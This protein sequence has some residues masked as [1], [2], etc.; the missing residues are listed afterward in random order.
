METKLRISA[1][2]LASVLVLLS[3]FLLLQ[4]PNSLLSD[5]KEQKNPLSYVAESFDEW[6]RSVIPSIKDGRSSGADVAEITGGKPVAPNLATCHEYLTVDGRHVMCCPPKGE[7]EETAIDF[8]FPDPSSPKRIRRPAHLLDRAYIAKYHKAV[9]LMKQLNYSDPRSFTRQANIHCI[10]CTGAHDQVNSS[11][12]FNIHKS[13]FFFPWHRFLIYFHERILGELIGDDTFA[14][15]YWNWDSPIGMQIPSFYMS[16]SFVDKDRDRAHF[17]PQIADLNYN[18]VESG[19]SPDQQIATNLAFMYHQM[20]SGAKKVELFMG[21]RR[22]AGEEGDCTAP[23]TIE[24]APHNTV[25][26]WVGS[27]L[28]PER[29]NMGSFYSAARD[30]IFYAHHANIDRLWIIWRRL[31]GNVPEIVDPAWLDSHFYF[32][33]ENARLIRVKLSDCLELEKLGYAYEETDLPWLNA[34]PKPS[35]PPRIA[36]HI[37]KEREIVAGFGPEGHTLAT[38][39]RTKVLRPKRFRS[40]KEREEEEE[41]LVVFGID[42]KRDIYVKFDVFVNAVDETSLGPESREFA[43]TFVN[44]PRGVRM[45]TD[46]GDSRKKKMKSSLKLGISELLEDLEAEE[47]ES[48]W[49]SLFPRNG[50]GMNTT[51]DGIRIEYMR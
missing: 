22:T 10:Y 15:P 16:G 30:P 2:C 40:K 25:H 9:T 37:L 42:V 11:A 6:L 43:G 3:T 24:A 23:G 34:R 7:L 13:W 17:P 46:D 33:D 1:I 35:I 19:L 12:R 45:V 29:E 27:N 41:V 5:G 39:I 28:M 14:L 44:L 36:R 26:G 18:D 31:R 47:D 21:C 51:V 4:N 32:H 50:T 8:Q 49:V 20:V 38:T 48:V